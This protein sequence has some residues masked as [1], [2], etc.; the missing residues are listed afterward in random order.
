MDV[1]ALPL[2]RVL[3]VSCLAVGGCCFRCS[4]SVLCSNRSFGY[5][6]LYKRYRSTVTVLMLMIFAFM[7]GSSLGSFLNVVVDRFPLMKSHGL[8]ALGHPPSRCD[9]CHKPIKPWMNIPV[10][11]W[12]YLRGKASCCGA[13]IPVR[14]L[15]MEMGAGLLAVVFVYA[16]NQFSIL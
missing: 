4:Y 6:V 16:L 10:F 8:S 1:P 5:R 14:V 9:R 13:I 3:Y 2:G 12:L 15:W 7:I 11:T